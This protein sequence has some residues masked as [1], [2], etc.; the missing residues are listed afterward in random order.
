MKL[1]AKS[2]PIKRLIAENGLSTVKCAKTVGLS[3]FTLDRFVSGQTCQ[4]K[5][6]K[7]FCDYFK[8]NMWDY[9]ELVD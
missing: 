2:E 9:F 3:P 8:L 5:T 1:K 6:A 7:I 4:T